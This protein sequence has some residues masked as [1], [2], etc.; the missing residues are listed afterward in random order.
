MI[1]CI[2]AGG[3]LT[4]LYIPGTGGTGV[5]RENSTEVRK[6]PVW[7]NKLAISAR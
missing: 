7:R 1:V 4:A 5:L 3:G 6:F 2:E